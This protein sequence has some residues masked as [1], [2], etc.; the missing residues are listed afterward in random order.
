[1]YLRNIN[2]SRSNNLYRCIPIRIRFFEIRYLAIRGKSKKFYRSNDYN[3]KFDGSFN[4]S[5]CNFQIYFHIGRYQR[6]DIRGNVY[7]DVHE[8]GYLLSPLYIQLVAVYSQNWTSA[9]IGLS[10]QIQHEH[11]CAS[12]PLILVIPSNNWRPS[13]SNGTDFS[14]YRTASACCF[15]NSITPREESN[16]EGY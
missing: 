2:I 7:I 9:K 11:R 10:N 4:V 12:S 14:I 6:I 16:F 8:R 15:W 3:R 1:M 13:R 5:H